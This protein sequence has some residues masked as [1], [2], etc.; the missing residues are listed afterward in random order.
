MPDLVVK[1]RFSHI[2]A[3]SNTMSA[4][5]SLS[6]AANVFQVVEFAGTVFS[7]GKNLYEL[8]DKAR[9]ASNNITLLLQE[10]QR[11]LSIIAYVRIVITEHVSSSF[12]H[13]LPNIHT[14]LTLIGKD[15]EHLR[16]I[17]AQ[18]IVSGAFELVFIV[19]EQR[20]IGTKG[21]G[22]WRFKIPTGSILRR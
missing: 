5:A 22:D 9:S 14:I 17:L 3:R 19:P 18:K 13:T 16:C 12:T 21:P 1:P 2:F 6:V 15:F 20:E 8:F 7:A 10:L 4:L 11:L